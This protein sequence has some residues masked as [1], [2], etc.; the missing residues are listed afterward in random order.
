[1]FGFKKI[2]TNKV[3][4]G[5]HDRRSYWFLQDVAIAT[6]KFIYRLL[7]IFAYF[8]YLVERLASEP[9]FL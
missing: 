8:P 7:K 5:C 3:W 1:M 4:L 6:C 2:V 9:T